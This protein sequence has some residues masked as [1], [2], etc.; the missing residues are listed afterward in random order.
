MIEPIELVFTVG[1]SPQH[2]F[3]VWA[4]RASLWWP[5]PHSWSGAPGLTVTFEPR[6]GGRIFERTPEGVEYDWGEVL[7]WE[8]PNRLAYLWHI[9]GDRTD[10]TEVEVTFTDRGDATAVT[11]VHTGWDRLGERGRE[12]QERNR[13][14]WAGVIPPYSAACT[15]LKV[16]E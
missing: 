12:L 11:I 6:S 14:G 2:A 3:D 7:V 1:C 4:T 10:A 9:Y 8:P 13:Q 15:S 16:H 5:R